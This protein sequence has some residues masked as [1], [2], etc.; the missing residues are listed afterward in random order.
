MQKQKWLQDLES[1]VDAIPYGEVSIPSIKRVNRKVVEVQTV[2]SETLR[3]NTNE[4]ALKDIV[5]F[6]GGLITDQVQGTVEFRVD[7]KPGLINL[8][9]IKNTKRT[10]YN[11]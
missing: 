5:Q 3:Y 2:C 7:L 6:L 9:T 10:D 1:Y 11:G 4:E 8:I